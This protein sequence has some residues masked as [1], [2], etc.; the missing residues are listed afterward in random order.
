MIIATAGH[1]DHGKT[2]LIKQLTG[3]DTDKLAEEKRRGLTIN[4]GFA[5]L[6]LDQESEQ[7]NKPTRI[8]FIDVPG[9]RRFI[10]TMI[11]GVSGIDMAM[12]VIA[13]NEGPMPQTK[14]HLEVLRLLGV[15]DIVVV[16]SFVDLVEA[17]QLEQTINAINSLFDNLG[18]MYAAIFEV[19]NSSG[20][21]IDSLSAHIKSS[22][23]K[24]A[25]KIDQQYF[26]MSI[27][28]SFTLSGT[29]LVLTGT[30]GS[31][32]VSVGD[33]LT[34]LPHDQE[35]R[36]RSIH[37]ENRESSN[38]V[39]GQRCAL[40]IVCNLNVADIERGDTLQDQKLCNSTSR[41]DVY[42]EKSLHLSHKLRHMLP[43]KFYLGAKKQSAKL[44]LAPNTKGKRLFEEDKG[45]VQL[46]LDTPISCCYGD[47]FLL[48][49][50]SEEFI[51][52]GGK[53]V[54]P[55]ASSSRSMNKDWQNFLQ[56][57]NSD[58]LPEILEIL[59]IDKNTE[60]N[61]SE[62]SQ[63]RNIPQL[64][65]SKLLQQTNLEQLI[66]SFTCENA[67]FCVSKVL[68]EENKQTILEQ[69][70]SWHKL[71]EQDEGMP[72]NSLTEPL[73]KISSLGL[74]EAAI[75]YLI[76]E[77]T[78]VLRGGFLSIV[79]REVSLSGEQTRIWES[80]QTLHD[81][82]H[83]S[84][85]SLSEIQEATGLEQKTLGPTLDFLTKKQYLFRVS[86]RRYVRAS[87]LQEFSGIVN[88]I[89]EHSDVIE[90]SVFRKQAGI[91]RNLGVELLEYFD[92]IRFTQRR[93]A[94]RVMINREIPEK[95]FSSSRQ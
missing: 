78:L 18:L 63:A 79:G 24:Y 1:V 54:N 38:A 43:V 91:G 35:V 17:P 57:L 80:I 62:L 93:G 73:S 89:A 22:A 48:R 14:E 4:L 81:K 19:S 76:E 56:T 95:L 26:R 25:A 52:G 53:L 82:A 40:N 10:N 88:Q 16:I 31:G 86:E 60:L 20:S 58:S 9:H 8:G 77:K 92:T 67:L 5:F 71:H 15:N 2:A 37:A 69:V 27:D 7:G 87:V 55:F 11:A 41:L 94:H 75:S 23:N 61:L 90:L 36:V 12:L 74:Q 45:Y 65:L 30:I 68:F 32:E 34:L 49:D 85:P 21:G 50:D 42:L 3:E 51:L 47:R 13:A 39:A 6:D 46:I 84:I 70:N 72:V 28:R 66:V 83:P 64:E 33:Q 59:L 44:A 29:G